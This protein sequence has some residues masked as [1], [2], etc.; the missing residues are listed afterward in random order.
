MVVRTLGIKGHLLQ[1]GTWDN[2][3]QVYAFTSLNCTTG[4]LTARL[5]PS[6]ARQRRKK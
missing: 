1:V 3:D 5:M 2:K 6:T 4:K